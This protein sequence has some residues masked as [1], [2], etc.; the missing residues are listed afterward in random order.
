M[1]HNKTR[2]GG[3]KTGKKTGKKNEMKLLS[4][5]FNNW[6]PFGTLVSA[7]AQKKEPEKRVTRSMKKSMEPSKR[8]KTPN[9]LT[10]PSSTATRSKTPPR[11]PRKMRTPSPPPAPR[12]RQLPYI[13]TQQRLLC[14]KHAFNNV[15]GQEIMKLAD[16][17]L[18]LEI[19]ANR[20]PDYV[21]DIDNYDLQNII[22]EMQNPR[23]QYRPLYSAFPINTLNSVDDVST[24]PK[25][26]PLNDEKR[27]STKI[28]TYAGSPF[29]RASEDMK[30]YINTLYESF[31]M[32]L[33]HTPDFSG[34]IFQIS[35]PHY[36]TGHYIAIRKLPTGQLQMIDSIGPTISD[37]IHFMTDDLDQYRENCAALIQ[38][39]F[40]K[41]GMELNFT[42]EEIG[43]TVLNIIIVKLRAPINRGVFY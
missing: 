19:P 8:S 33:K 27:K 40:K 29:K 9:L 5:E 7:Q 41:A 26:T 34:L 31:L 36:D 38:M 21:G 18:T 11:P 43:E 4:N 17:F 6:D 42:E 30:V 35:Y 1:R 32:L 20:Q 37:P 3:S 39:L 15:V 2:R 14:G 24:W 23:G 16:I 12:R 25:N 22:N 28:L 13:E 10:F